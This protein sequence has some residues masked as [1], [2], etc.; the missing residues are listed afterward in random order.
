MHA[1]PPSANPTG[2]SSGARAC[3]R[4]RAVFRCDGGERFG[5]GHVARCLPLA[6]ALTRLGWQTSFAGAYDGLAEWL[7]ERSG[8][9]TAAPDPIAPCGVDPDGCELAI[10]D[11]YTIAT[12]AICEL[13]ETLPVLTLAEASRCSHLGIL[14]DYHL[15]RE[16]A[17]E[18]RLLAGPA[19]APLDPAFAAAGRPGTDVHKLL[20]TVGGSGA[21]AALQ[22]EIAARAAAAF[23][24]A[25]V[26]LAGPGTGSFTGAC[27]C[28]LETFTASNGRIHRLPHPSS[29]LE[30]A[31]EID[32]AVTAAGLT[33]Y[34]LAC[35]GVPQ[36][37]IA[38][39]DN[40][41]RV[42]D[43]LRRRDL[44]VCLDLTRGDS[45]SDLPSALRRISEPALRR[46]LSERGMRV[47][48]GRGAE[49][50]ATALTELLG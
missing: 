45:L 10:V 35:A 37:A 44:A 42:V 41:R 32:L 3:A 14:L 39:A 4:R 48:D 17:C 26:L 49:R 36:L 6:A 43:G 47:F 19:Y 34:E 18:P 40:Q 13:A 31:S 30:V 28:K 9:M 27:E 25:E 46:D 50:A 2:G 16:T 7:V 24:N 20:V 8:A 1:R 15:D 29:L 23:P 5:A 12:A 21:A 33:S 11:S 38:V 22:G